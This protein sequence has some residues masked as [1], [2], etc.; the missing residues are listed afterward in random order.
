MFSMF[1]PQESDLGECIVEES[2]QV[3]LMRHHAKLHASVA[4]MHA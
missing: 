4:R 1:K 2:M 3:L